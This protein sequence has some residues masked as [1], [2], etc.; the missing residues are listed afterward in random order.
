MTN[1]SVFHIFGQDGNAVVHLRQGSVRLG[2][3]LRRA[4]AIRRVVN[5]SVFVA[6]ADPSTMPIEPLPGAERHYVATHQTESELQASNRAQ[7]IDT[8]PRR[9]RR[10]PLPT[11]SEHSANRAAGRIR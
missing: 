9:T 3:T 11:A 10:D 4:T 6:L 2:R 1:Q 5:H 8:R 7:L